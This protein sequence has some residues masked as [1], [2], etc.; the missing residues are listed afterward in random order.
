MTDPL[1]HRLTKV[2]GLGF[3]DAAALQEICLDPLHV[4]DGE[5]FIRAGERSAFTH[6][7][8]DGWAARC[9][10]LADGSRQ[11]TALLLPG[12]MCDLHCAVVG[13]L[14][15]EVVALT[16]VLLGRIPSSRLS[17]LEAFRPPIAAAL[18]W[19]ALIDQGILRAWITN[20][21]LREA[22]ARVAH[23]LCEL[24]LRLRAVGMVGDHQFAMPLTQSELAETLG[25]TPVHI[26]R[27]VQRL[28]RHGAIR[29]E[30]RVLTLLDVAR[31]KASADFDP[32][33][34]RFRDD[35]PPEAARAELP[36]MPRSR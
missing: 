22:E 12:D 14:D 2:A 18:W 27:V 35:R 13:G 36:S 11:I 15:H 5:T 25:L 9:E 8:R 29:L 19:T 30:G 26:N 16:P 10:G 34:L 3:D 20:I 1:I 28:R 7:I 4:G 23:L 24:H 6:Y 33:Y 17:D 32:G 31:L 21:G